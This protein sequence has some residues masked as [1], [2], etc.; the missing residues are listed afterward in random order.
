[1]GELAQGLACCHL[2]R[3]TARWMSSLHF[4]RGQGGG[5]RGD[6]VM[7]DSSGTKGSSS[8][9]GWHMAHHTLN[10]ACDACCHGSTHSLTRPGRFS[11]DTG[12]R[13]DCRGIVMT[14]PSPAGA[15]AS[16]SEGLVVEEQASLCY[17]NRCHQQLHC[18]L[19]LAGRPRVLQARLRVQLLQEAKAL[20]LATALVR[21]AAL[22]ALV[23]PAM[24]P[25]HQTW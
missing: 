9:C 19:L 23:Q 2:Q 24:D 17:S 1:M 8:T 6:A 5:R 14:H 10:M 15:R 18:C 13:T 20:H 4:D 25:H 22:A 12:H 21:G 16:G 11:V 3:R 7:S